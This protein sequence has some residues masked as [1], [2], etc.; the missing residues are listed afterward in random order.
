MD[1]QDIWL[2]EL[3]KLGTVIEKSIESKFVSLAKLKVAWGNH[4]RP[5]SYNWVQA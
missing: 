3:A 2:I 1:E 4:K 5:A